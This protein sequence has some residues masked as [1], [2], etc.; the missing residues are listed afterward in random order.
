M[1]VPPI[2]LAAIVGPFLWW[3]FMSVFL[4]LIRRFAPKLERI[5]FRDL[6]K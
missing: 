6:L 5:L 1:E 2:L 3:I 4:W